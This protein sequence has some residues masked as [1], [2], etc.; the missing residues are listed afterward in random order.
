[1]MEVIYSVGCVDFMGGEKYEHRILLHSRQND[2][3]LVLLKKM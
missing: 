2:D 3:Y 1:M